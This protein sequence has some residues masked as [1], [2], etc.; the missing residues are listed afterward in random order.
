MSVDDDVLMAE[1]GAGDECPLGVPPK[2]RRLAGEK[3]CGMCVSL[4]VEP[5][6]GL[7]TA[8]WAVGPVAPPSGATIDCSSRVR[9]TVHRF[10]AEPFRLILWPWTTTADLFSYLRAATGVATE[11][12]TCYHGWAYDS[13]RP[14]TKLPKS[15]RT[16]A[17][18]GVRDGSDVRVWVNNSTAN[19]RQV[20]LRAVG[21]PLG[22]FE[23][24]LDTDIKTF[25]EIAAFVMAIT[26]SDTVLTFHASVFED[27]DA[28][29][30]RTLRDYG[31]AK[32]EAI[33]V[34]RRGAYGALKLAGDARDTLGDPVVKRRRGVV[35]Y[36]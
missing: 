12:L 23:V 5:G 29:G 18:C 16:L 22:T 17:D 26:P 19:L 15:Q 7:I 9:L 8:C 35:G 11:Y 32:E 6:L 31:V 13:R 36:S 25:R 34:F 27:H 30:R 20:L 2:R 28:L 1:D 4:C 10:R 14:V 21:S 3:E 33:Y 24:D